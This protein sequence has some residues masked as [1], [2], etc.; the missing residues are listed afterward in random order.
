M[1]LIAETIKECIEKTT[2]LDFKDFLKVVDRS[3][4]W[5]LLS[6]F[7]FDDDKK[8]SNVLTFSV[9]LCH[10]K[11]ENIKSYIRQFQPKDIKKSSEA[12]DGFLRYLNSPVIF[13]FSFIIQKK[14]NYFSRSLNNDS[15]NLYM[16][17]L[18][19]WIKVLEKDNLSTGIYLNEVSK[20]IKEFREST[21]AK[22]FNW[23]LM[24]K[25]LITS[26]IAS[27]IFYELTRNNKP[28]SICW[29]SDRDGIV[30]KYD[31]ISL[32]IAF[33]NFLLL[34]ANDCIG[35]QYLDLSF[36]PKIG[37]LTSKANSLD[38][39]E[40]LVRIPDFIAGT[41]AELDGTNY[42]FN[43]DKY[44]D[45]FYYSIVNSKNHS[46]I[47]MDDIENDFYIRRVKYV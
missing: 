43:H 24:R 35:Q 14:D 27:I 17:G 31:S 8:Q 47:A 39:Y 15:I 7:C 26:C 29:I 1:V 25:I 37:F 20:R 34:L 19:S 4:S 10:D 16:N 45:I 36:I 30:E 23:K 21:K 5:F 13:H 18:Q 6:D 3:A 38:D 28:M 11:T 2:L 33:L 32:D 41:I 40:E 42:K 22:A 12:R 9:L 44:E 46:M